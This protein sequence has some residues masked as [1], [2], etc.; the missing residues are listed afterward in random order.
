M[1]PSYAPSN[2]GFTTI[3][4]V[5][6]VAA[7]S[8]SLIRLASYR[9]LGRFF[10]W[11][12]SIKDDQHLVTTG[13]YAIV[14]HPGYTG[15][16]MLMG[17]SYLFLTGSGGLLRECGWLDVPGVALLV[18]VWAGILVWVAVMMVVRTGREDRVLKKQFAA[19][20]ERYAAKTP[21]KLLPF[22]F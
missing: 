14:R 6:C 3:W 4:M 9:E 17:G 13:P 7:I 11:E 20:W 22:V 18:Q 16:I 15:H 5:G 1:R 2:V 8:G 12:L 21:Y 10:T 19:E